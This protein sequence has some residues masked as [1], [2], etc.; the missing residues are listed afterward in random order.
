MKIISWNCKMRFRDD[1]DRVC[2]LKPDLLIIPESEKINLIGRFKLESNGV[3]DSCWVGDNPNK[4]LAIFTFNNFKIKLFRD[5]VDKYK[6]ILPVT[7]IKDSI[8]YKVIA[9]WAKKTGKIKYTQQLIS[10]LREYENFINN[11]NIIICGDFNSN[12]YWKR[13]GIDNNHQEILNIL[14][15]KKIYSSYHNY[16]KEKQGRESKA[17]YYHYH[18]KDRP[19]HIDFCFLSESLLAKVKNIKILKYDD[20]IN[21]SDHVPIIVQT[22]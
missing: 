7:I 10:A 13:S 8:S 2:D 12:L 14:D 4:G 20:W 15:S 18:K 16:Y 11:G 21:S 22:D 3:S 9:V 19:F 5:Y 6:Y 1:I 17:T